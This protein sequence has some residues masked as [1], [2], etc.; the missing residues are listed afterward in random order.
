LL[1]T[2][3]RVLQRV[4]THRHTGIEYLWE[5]AVRDFKQSDPDRWRDQFSAIGEQIQKAWKPT[6]DDAVQSVYRY[7]FEA[8]GGNDEIGYIA[9]ETHSKSEL[10]AVSAAVQLFFSERS[11]ERAQRTLRELKAENQARYRSAISRYE[12]MSQKLKPRTETRSVSSTAGL[13]YKAR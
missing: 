8:L 10:W 7:W 1:N 11:D 9:Q 6:I 13:D 5:R 3:I 4:G 12:I 2:S